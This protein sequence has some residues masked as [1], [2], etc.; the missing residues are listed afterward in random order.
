[1]TFDTSTSQALMKK[2]LYVHVKE[3]GSCKKTFTYAWDLV[4]PVCMFFFRDHKS[5]ARVYVGLIALHV[6]FL[7]WLVI[8]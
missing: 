1:M 5:T 4:K 3:C 8:L 2:I 7:C 6:D